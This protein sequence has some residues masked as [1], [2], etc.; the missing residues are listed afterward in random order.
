MT[1]A[2][3][4]AALEA[5]RTILTAEAVRDRTAESARV[6]PTS[7]AGTLTEKMFTPSASSRVSLLRSRLKIVLAPIEA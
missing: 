1:D 5:A 7:E 3:T 6:V 4:D 2:A